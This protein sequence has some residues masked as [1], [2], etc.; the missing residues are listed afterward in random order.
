MDR[1]SECRDYR[2]RDDNCENFQSDM[3]TSSAAPVEI[4]VHGQHLQGPESTQLRGAGSARVRSPSSD[5]I[6]PLS[7]GHKDLPRT[8]LVM[9]HFRGGWLQ[10]QTYTCRQVI[11]CV[12]Q[13]AFFGMLVI[14]A[15]CF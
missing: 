10:P 8:V 6:S 11:P 14:A 2:N 7:R 3:G 5:L 15:T 4:V 13:I 1:R 9:A 12:T